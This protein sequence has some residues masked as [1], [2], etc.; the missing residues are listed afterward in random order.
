VRIDLPGFETEKA[1]EN[2]FEN[3]AVKKSFDTASAFIINEPFTKSGSHN[4]H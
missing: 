1:S 2:N 3:F 4:S